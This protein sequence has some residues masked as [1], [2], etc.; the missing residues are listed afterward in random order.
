MRSALRR[1]RQRVFDLYYPCHVARLRAGQEGDAVCRVRG[2]AANQ[3]MELSRHVLVH[4]KNVHCRAWSMKTTVNASATELSKKRSPA[5]RFIA[6]AI[7]IS[8]GKI[9]F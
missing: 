4:K 5:D 2:K 6:N 9:R 3:V 1:S 7:E 8:S